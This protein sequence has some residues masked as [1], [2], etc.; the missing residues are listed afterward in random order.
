MLKKLEKGEEDNHNTD[1]NK[2]KQE[3][4]QKPKIIKMYT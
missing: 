4:K 3:T 2:R 1:Q